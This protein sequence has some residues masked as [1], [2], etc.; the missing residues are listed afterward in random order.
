M[1]TKKGLMLITLLLLN[2]CARDL[3]SNVYTSDS[4][5]S[6][7]LEGTI[8]SVRN[9]KIKDNDNIS[10]NLLAIRAGGEL[11]HVVGLT[12]S[13]N[14]RNVAV[15]AVGGSIIGATAGAVA[16]GVLNTRNGY[17]Y[18]V[19]ADRNQ[20][21]DSYYAGGRN[22]RNALSSINTSGIISIIQGTKEKQ[23]NVMLSEGDKVYI[24][25]SENRTMIIPNN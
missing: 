4:T 20:I 5:L 9:I 10:K 7:I 21:K 22:I 12:S 19:K 18:I 6:V 8:I 2:G 15:A 14:N 13:I 24:I 16:Q 25:I 17:E 11:G 1:H 23:K 3:S